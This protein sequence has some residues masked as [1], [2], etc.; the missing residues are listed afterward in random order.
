[1]K[2]G[3]CAWQDPGCILFRL[4]AAMATL[5]NWQTGNGLPCLYAM[6][7]RQHAGH[8]RNVIIL[9]VSRLN[10]KKTHKH[11]GGKLGFSHQAQRKHSTA[12]TFNELCDNVQPDEVQDFG[13]SQRA[14]SD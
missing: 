6:P 1:M 12:P 9:A 10:I 3:L 4:L 7:T 11:T 13:H 5:R 14:Q 8:A 2:S